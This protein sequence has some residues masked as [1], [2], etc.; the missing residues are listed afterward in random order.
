MKD[1]R[2]L[3]INMIWLFLG[4]GLNVACF[5]GMLEDYWGAL[6]TGLIAAS[7]I[8]LIRYARYK[9]NDTYREKVDIQVSDERNQYISNKAWAWAGYLFVL[10]AAV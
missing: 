5:N 10:V 8:Q 6:G 9:I 1:R 7:A 4:I 3:V 2:V